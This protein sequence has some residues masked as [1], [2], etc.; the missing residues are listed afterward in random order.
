MV[1]KKFQRKLP[2]ETSF[3]FKDPKDAGDFYDFINSKYELDH[4]NV[5]FNVPFELNGETLYLTYYEIERM[6]ETL[7]LPLVFIDATLEQKANTTLFDNNYT[8][9]KGHWYIRLT[10]YDED[11]RNCLL[12][13]HPLKNQVIEYLK[14]LKSQ[15][16]TFENY[17]ELKFIKKS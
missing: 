10:V 13:N 12:D 14:T 16:L 3:I 4:V 7:N 2:R 8:S 1:A 17:E 15:Y 11:I 6:D 5:G 9:R